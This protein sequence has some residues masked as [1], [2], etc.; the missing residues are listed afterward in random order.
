MVIKYIPNLFDK[1]DRKEFEI[2]EYKKLTVKELLKQGTAKSISQRCRASGV[3]TA[4]GLGL[5]AS[6]K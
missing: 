3:W 2:E 6:H 4:C 1:T 5:C